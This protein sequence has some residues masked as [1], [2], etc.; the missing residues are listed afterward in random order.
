MALQVMSPEL[1]VQHRIF[2]ERICSCA[3]IFDLIAGVLVLRTASKVIRSLR[4]SATS[5]I[6]RNDVLNPRD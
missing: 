3:I 6:L 5:V 1:I 2:G 4:F